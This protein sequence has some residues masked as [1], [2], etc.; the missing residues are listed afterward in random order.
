LQQL[1]ISHS[2]LVPN[3]GGLVVEKP[4]YDVIDEDATD[5]TLLAMLMYS[6]VLFQRLLKVGLGKNSLSPQQRIARI[7]EIT[8]KQMSNAINA[9]Q[10]TAQQWQTPT[11]QHEIVGQQQGDEEDC[12]ED[13]K[14]NFDADNGQLKIIIEQSICGEIA[15]ADTVPSLK[16]INSIID[17][18]IADNSFGA[19]AAAGTATDIQNSTILGTTIVR[20]LEA[21]DSIFADKVVTLRQQLAVCGFATC[22]CLRGLHPATVVSQICCWPKTNSFHPQ[23]LLACMSKNHNFLS[24]RLEMEFF[25]IVPAQQLGSQLS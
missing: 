14:T 7:T 3:A 23:Q 10:H 22:R 18:G 8:L 1:H 15:L 21:S 2:T 5:I 12:G 24:V 4:E 9:L 17:A 16:I 6:V 20:S 13:S 11:N 25:T 19:I